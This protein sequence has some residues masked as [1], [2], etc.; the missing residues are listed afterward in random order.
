MNSAMS[1]LGLSLLLNAAQIPAVESVEFSKVRQ[2]QLVQATVR[3]RNVA[4]NREGS[5]VLIGKG[6]PFVYVLTAQHV[7]QGADRLEIAVFSNESYPVPKK[8]YR[9]GEIVAELRG[10]EDLALVRIRTADNVPG[11]LRICPES[12][13]PNPLVLPLLTIG[14]ESRNSP[15]PLLEK[16]VEKKMAQKPGTKEP[17]SFWMIDSKYSAG[18]SGGPLIDKRGYVLGICS[19]TNRDKSYFTHIDEIHRFLKNNGYRWLSVEK[20]DK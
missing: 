3:I 15:T 5:G 10:P 20:E 6:G 7:V 14:C 13:I 18:R 19:G 1:V 9:S 2:I 17:A 8:T 16:R 4:L 11:F 12:K